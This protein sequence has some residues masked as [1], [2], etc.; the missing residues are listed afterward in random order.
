M[1]DVLDCE[2]QLINVAVQL[3]LKEPIANS[4]NLITKSP[5]RKLRSSPKIDILKFVSFNNPDEERKEAIQNGHEKTWIKSET[6]R[7][8]ATER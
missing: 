7:K 2:L 3:C 5:K 4:Q 1:T 8:L 6:E